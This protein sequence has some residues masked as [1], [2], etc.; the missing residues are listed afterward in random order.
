LFREN[1]RGARPACTNGYS[2]CQLGTLD[3]GAIKTAPSGMCTLTF[4]A[5]DEWGLSSTV[6]KSF[7]LPHK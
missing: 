1:T 6:T 4:T 5:L 2:R 3:V 7:T